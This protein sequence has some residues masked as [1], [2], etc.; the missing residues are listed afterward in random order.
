MECVHSVICV[1]PFFSSILTVFLSFLTVFFCFLTYVLVIRAKIQMLQWDIK[2]SPFFCLFLMYAGRKICVFL[3][4]SGWNES[5]ISTHLASLCISLFLIRLPL[6]L[7][8]SQLHS[9]CFLSAMQSICLCVCFIF[10]SNIPTK[11]GISD[12]SDLVETF[13]WFK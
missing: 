4:F 9:E 10:T 3:N 6:A 1:F 12:T 13:G 11:I 7:D 8:K 5:P 2:V